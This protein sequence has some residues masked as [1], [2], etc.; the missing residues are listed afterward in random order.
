MRHRT[1]THHTAETH[2]PIAALDMEAQVHTAHQDRAAL[3]LTARLDPKTLGHTPRW[4]QTALAHTVRRDQ[5]TLDRTVHQD[6]IALDH[7]VRLDQ[8][9]RAHRDMDRQ[10]LMTAPA[11]VTPDHH[12]TRDLKVATRDQRQQP[13]RQYTSPK[14]TKLQARKHTDI[15]RSLMITVVAKAPSRRLMNTR[16]TNPRLRSIKHTPRLM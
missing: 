1:E 2:H 12:T 5:K 8:K 9:T 13:Q 3:A 7:M 10:A 4:D 11:M 6:Q 16:P 15:S 14:H